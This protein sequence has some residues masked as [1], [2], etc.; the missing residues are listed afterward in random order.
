MSPKSG[1]IRT[2]LA[3]EEAR[4]GTDDGGQPIIW[5]FNGWP[6]FKT[7]PVPLPPEQSNHHNGGFAEWPRVFI[8]RKG[9]WIDLG[10]MPWNSPVYE[11]S[12]LPGWHPVHCCG[13]FC[14]GQDGNGQCHDQQ[15]AGPPNKTPLQ[16]LTEGAWSD[17]EISEEE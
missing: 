16:E 9:E 13:V 2:M 1:Y 7:V 17:E 10:A 15:N 8:R 3:R 12:R 6:T 14:D 5:R 4:C 11:L